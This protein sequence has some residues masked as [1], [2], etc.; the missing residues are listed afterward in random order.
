MIEHH[1]SKLLICQYISVSTCFQLHKNYRWTW[2]VTTAA[3]QSAICWNY[4]MLYKIPIRFRCLN[5]FVFL[6]LRFV[7]Y[8]MWNDVWSNIRLFNLTFMNLSLPS[9]N[10]QSENKATT[11]VIMVYQFVWKPGV[12]QRYK[13]RKNRLFGIIKKWSCCVQETPWGM[14]HGM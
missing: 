2:R 9:F 6:I 8:I 12:W 5:S 11:I 1:L 10:P 13:M 7:V 14:L 3:K 4:V